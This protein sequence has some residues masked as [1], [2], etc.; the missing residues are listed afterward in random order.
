M[1]QLGVTIR[2]RVTKFQGIVIGRVAYLTGCAQLL[3]QPVVNGK[4][5]WAESRWIDEPRAEVMD[6]KPITIPV[7][8]SA[9]ALQRVGGDKAAPRR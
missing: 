8:Q 9:P 7:D 4:G 6:T 2:D 3:V 1:I 5:E